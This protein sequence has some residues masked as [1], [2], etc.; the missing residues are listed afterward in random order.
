MLLVRNKETLCEELG[1]VRLRGFSKTNSITEGSHNRIVGFIRRTYDFRNFEKFRL[2][3]KH[4]CFYVLGKIGALG[5]T[6]TPMGLLPVDFESTA[7]T[8]SATRALRW[9]Q[10]LTKGSKNLK[11]FI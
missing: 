9:P 3:I 1:A 5:E 4:Y 2:R 6:R 7:S 11:K 8:D 10:T